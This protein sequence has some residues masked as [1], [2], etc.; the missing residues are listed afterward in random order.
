MTRHSAVIMPMD[1]YKQAIEKRKW[2]VEF[3]RQGEEQKQQEVPCGSNTFIK[4]STRSVT[5]AVSCAGTAQQVF[6][7]GG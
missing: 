6:Q 4:V 7:W 3:E 2:Q 5:R 1:I